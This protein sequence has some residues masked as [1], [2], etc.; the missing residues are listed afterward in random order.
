MSESAE[1][2]LP[3][4]IATAEPGEPV[5]TDHAL[6]IEGEHIADIGPAASLRERHRSA[7]PRNLPDTLLCPGFVNAHTHAA[8]SLMRGFADDLP[9][10]DWLQKRIWPAEGRCVSPDFVYDGSVL[11][12]YEMLLGGTTCFNDMYFFP[13]QTARAAV[14][15]GMR[16]QV[17]IIVI[18]F[19]SPY[20]TGPED[21][22]RKGLAL[23]DANREEPLLSF[24]LAP[25]APYTVSDDAFRSV[26][27]LA[28]ELQLPIHL[29]IHET[30]F[31]LAEGSR[32]HGQ[33]PLRASTGSVSWARA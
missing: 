21:Y 25:H 15:L 14:S 23:R 2:L 33:R 6:L 8:M 27:T 16:A 17:G 11:A 28:D 1:L 20:G 29:H 22:L 32:I 18:D 10:H 30:A 13:E 26:T 9:L 4:W 31:E 24:A 12:G 7:I 3:R 5:L 19:P